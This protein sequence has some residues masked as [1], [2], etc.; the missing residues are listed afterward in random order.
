MVPCFVVVGTLVL[1]SYS[2]ASF[3]MGLEL[4]GRSQNLVVHW[5]RHPVHPQPWTVL[6]HGIRRLKPLSYIADR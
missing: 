5:E 3:S 6:D 2:E 1:V 4:H